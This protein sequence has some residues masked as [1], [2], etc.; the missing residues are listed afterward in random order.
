MF[1]DCTLLMMR[2]GTLAHAMGLMP[3]QQMKG[4]RLCRRKL[5]LQRDLPT[6]G[7]LGDISNWVVSLGVVD[8]KMPNN[9]RIWIFAR[10]KTWMSESLK[11]GLGAHRN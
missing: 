5:R 7:Q 10:P 6:L 11:F 2:P 4:Q 9:G 1:R 8:R 3:Q